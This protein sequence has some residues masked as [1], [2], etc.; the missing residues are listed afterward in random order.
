MARGRSWGGGGGGR[1]LIRKRG[2]HVLTLAAIKSLGASA[3][4]AIEEVQNVVGILGRTAKC[5]RPETVLPEHARRCARRLESGRRAG[6]GRG[7]VL[8]ARLAVER[9]WHHG[10]LL[11]HYARVRGKLD[12]GGRR[13]IP[14]IIGKVE[15]RPLTV[16]SLALEQVRLH[17]E[18]VHK[19]A[20]LAHERRLLRRHGPAADG[21]QV[22]SRLSEA[23]T[24]GLAKQPVCIGPLDRR[25]RNASRIEVVCVAA[26]VA[27]LGLP[28]ERKTAAALGL[29]FRG[30]AGATRLLI[31]HAARLFGRTHGPPTHS[32]TG[33]EER[34]VEHIELVGGQV[35]A[36]LGPRKRAAFERFEQR[37]E[38][39]LRNALSFLGGS[40]RGRFRRASSRGSS[41][42]RSGRRGPSGGILNGRLGSRRQ[43]VRD[44]RAWRCTTRGMAASATP[45]LRV[46]RPVRRGRKRGAVATLR[47]ILTRASGHGLRDRKSR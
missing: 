21:A 15:A 4:A 17:R 43:R 33:I 7:V 32:T 44:C 10:R 11:R 36:Q 19:V 31:T 8:A 25:L 5:G 16:V 30:L 40:T 18:V 9:R 2:E 28:T 29:A 6:H 1:V 14:A 22:R 41:S 12:R 20:R 35:A 38:S 24:D 46:P 23:G 13:D 39:V 34:G 3:P 26:V 42:R 45:Y 47:A 37:L 27:V